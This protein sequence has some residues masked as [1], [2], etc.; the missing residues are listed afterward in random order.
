MSVTSAS[1]VRVKKNTYSV[2]SKL[3][4]LKLD[5]HVGESEVRFTYE[6]N[7]VCRL[8][9]LPGQQA[10]HRLSPHHHLAGAQTRGL[11]RLH[12]PG[13]AISHGRLPPGLRPAVRS[14]KS[15]RPMP[16]IFNFSNSPPVTVSVTSPRFWAPACARARLPQPELVRA[17]LNTDR[18]APLAMA[19]FVP[20]LKAYDSLLTEVSA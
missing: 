6:G 10:L 4:G 7:E 20:D 8:P 9:R 2:P 5:A 14:W 18:S 17:R 15:V 1:T 19:P 11:P 16:A 3:I 12:L 13:G